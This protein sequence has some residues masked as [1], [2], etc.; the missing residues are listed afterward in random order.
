[1]DIWISGPHAHVMHL[2]PIACMYND[3]YMISARVHA[4]DT[5]PNMYIYIHT[6]TLSYSVLHLD[7][8]TAGDFCCRNTKKK[9][10]GK[11][12]SLILYYRSL[13]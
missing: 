13:Q 9:K 10:K 7:N 11:K 8:C 4:H 6:H 3:I 2:P 5:H 1:M 12:M